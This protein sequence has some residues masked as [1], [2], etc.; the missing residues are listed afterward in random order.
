MCLSVLGEIYEWP[1]KK[2][3]IILCNTSHRVSPELVGINP[4]DLQCSEAACAR[5]QQRSD[6]KGTLTTTHSSLPACLSVWLSVGRYGNAESPEVAADWLLTH[7]VGGAVVWWGS[8]GCWS[9]AGFVYSERVS[10]EGRVWRRYR[11]A[12]LKVLSL[13]GFWSPESVGVRVKKNLYGMIWT[14]KD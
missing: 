10:E 1:H 14:D 9:S 12:S 3:T 8:T 11:E 13:S 6:H 7:P 4:T 2:K 5:S